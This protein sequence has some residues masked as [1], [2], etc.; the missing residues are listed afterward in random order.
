M[1]PEGPSVA[2]PGRQ[3][4][5]GGGHETSAEG[6]ALNDLLLVECRAFGANA[7]EIFDPGLTAGASHWRLRALPSNQY[8]DF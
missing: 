1:R 6:A 7:A 2:R 4:G 3:A 8:M 5:M